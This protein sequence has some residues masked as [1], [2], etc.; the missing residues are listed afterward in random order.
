MVSCRRILL[1]QTIKDKWRLIFWS[2]GL[3]EVIEKQSQIDR[4]IIM[5]MQIFRCSCKSV[6][7]SHGLIVI[8]K[9]TLDFQAH[10]SG[11]ATSVVKY[12]ISPILISL[13]SH[14]FMSF[15]CERSQRKKI[16]LCKSW[17]QL[18]H[19]EHLWSSI[20]VKLLK[21]MPPYLK[22][23]CDNCCLEKKKKKLNIDTESKL[24]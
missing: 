12:G 11:V 13:F 9:A 19:W 3:S 4:Q 17:R 21:W 2:Y 24:C 20:Y 10:H 23:R 18:W 22:I 6:V 14:V 8:S 16:Y 7:K 5:N 1:N 15:I